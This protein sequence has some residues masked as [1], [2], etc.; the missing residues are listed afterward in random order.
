MTGPMTEFMECGPVPIDRF[1]VSRRRWHLN[2]IARHIVVGARTADAEIRTGCRNQRLGS[3][4]NL[5]WWRRDN[6]SSDLLGQTIALV[7]VE[8]GKAL[9]KRDGARLLAGFGGAPTFVVRSEAIG[10]D[11]GRSP[12]ALPDV[13]A[14]RERLT[15]GEPALSR[16]A[17]LDDGTQRISTLIPEYPRCVAALRGIARGALIAAV[18]HGCTHGIRP[19][20]SSAMILSVI[21]V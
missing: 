18:P 6:R 3:G 13:A 12:F 19:A 15:K 16:E 20:S 5:A 9:E 10:I 1:E 2:E 11:D 4:L 21:S 14:E 7:Y 8:D 17:V